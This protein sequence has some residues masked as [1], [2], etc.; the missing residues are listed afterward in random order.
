MAGF[1][2]GVAPDVDKTP[3]D[4]GR[5]LVIGLAV[6]RVLCLVLAVGLAL[7][8]RQQVGELTRERDRARSE[9]QELSASGLAQAKIVLATRLELAE[10]THLLTVARLS[11]YTGQDIRDPALPPSITGKRRDALTAAFALKQAKGF[12]TWGGRRK[13]ASTPWVSSASPFP[14]RACPS[15]RRSSPRRAC[16]ACST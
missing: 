9:V 5:V 6:A 3:R 11:P 16:R 12:F 15:R 14:R 4:S 7:P 1:E 2:N 10:L 13:T 8:N